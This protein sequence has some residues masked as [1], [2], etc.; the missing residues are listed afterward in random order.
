LSRT[1]DAEDDHDPGLPGSDL[2]A[3]GSAAASG[4]AGRGPAFSSGLSVKEFALLRRAG[5]QP[6]AQVMGASVVRAGWQYLPALAPGTRS[7][8][9]TTGSGALGPGAV[10]A[11]MSGYSAIYTEPS[12][13]Q[14][15]GYLWGVDVVCDLGTL[16]E[17][18]NLARR[19]AIDRLLQEAVQVGA[20]AVVGVCLARSDHDLG[21]GLL[22]Y[23]VSGTAVRIPG[24]AP[25]DSPTLTDLSGQDYWRLREGG[26]EPAGLLASTSVTFCSAAR[27]TRLRRRRGTMRAQELVEIGEAFQAARAKVRSAMR[28]QVSRCGGTNAVGVEFSHAISNETFE[29]GSSLASSSRQGWHLSRVGIPYRVKGS[30]LAKRRGW[31]ITM[32]GAG[33]AVRPA[34]RPATEPVKSTIRLGAR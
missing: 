9:H 22:E 34:E 24:Q 15:S 16:S 26:F 2:S 31:M 5:P 32:H 33:T 17:A 27:S 7:G 23:A 6:L 10:P 20:D 3:G 14:I 11:G 25:T 19:Q 21:G 28:D 30:G 4:R 18:W 12:P 1:G 8:T 13:Q 29:L